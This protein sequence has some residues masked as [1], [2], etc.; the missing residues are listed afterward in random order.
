[1]TVWDQTRGNHV[2]DKYHVCSTVKQDV[3][4][5]GVSIDHRKMAS[6]P[7]SAPF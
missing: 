5:R 6:T 2:S 7:L 1:M 4:A 3:V